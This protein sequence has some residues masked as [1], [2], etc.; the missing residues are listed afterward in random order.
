MHVCCSIEL[1]DVIR[2]QCEQLENLEEVSEEWRKSCNGQEECRY[3]GSGK[4]MTSYHV[5]SR[6]PRGTD[7]NCRG[8]RDR[9][10][11]N[12]TLCGLRRLI[13]HS[14]D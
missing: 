5:S 11:P 12:I 8:P 4:V 6:P 7:K 10:P 14:E 2:G 1:S 9:K 3:G 13:S